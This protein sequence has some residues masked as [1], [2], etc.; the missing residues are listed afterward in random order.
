MRIQVFT[1]SWSFVVH[2]D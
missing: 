1:L 2:L